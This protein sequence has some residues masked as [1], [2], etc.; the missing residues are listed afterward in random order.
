MF[1][2]RIEGKAASVGAR[3]LDEKH[4]GWAGEVDLDKLDMRHGNRCVLGLV[5]GSYENGLRVLGLSG[6]RET[7]NTHGFHAFHGRSYER[8]DRVWKKEIASRRSATPVAG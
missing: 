4:P 6:D 5:Y 3:L 1:W 7:T 2:D 8:L